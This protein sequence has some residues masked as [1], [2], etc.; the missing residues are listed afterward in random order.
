[1]QDD[2]R[3][4]CFCVHSGTGLSSEA[5]DRGLLDR[6]RASCISNFL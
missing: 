2:T 1:M 3:H 6:A 5:V 4:V